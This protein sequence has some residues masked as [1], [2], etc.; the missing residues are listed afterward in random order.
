VRRETLD[1]RRLT[2]ARVG[3][4]SSLVSGRKKNKHSPQ[5]HKG[6]EGRNAK[7]EDARRWIG[8]SVVRVVRGHKGKMLT[9]EITEDTEE[10]KAN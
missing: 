8:S 1:D 6:H 10:E 9:A 3:A 2:D 5:R 7:K 4:R